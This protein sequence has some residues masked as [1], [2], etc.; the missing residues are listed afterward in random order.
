MIG[1]TLNLVFEDFR[2]QT[3]NEGDNLYVFHEVIDKIKKIF[4]HFHLS[5]SA[6]AALEQELQKSNQRGVKL[7]QHVPTQWIL[8]YQ[9]LDRFLQIADTVMFV[10]I[11]MNI[12]LPF[13]TAQYILFVQDLINCLN[14]CN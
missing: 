13:V 5:I 12:Y 14:D 9:M 7:I 11:K 10:I 4:T 6:T 8:T 2:K 3:T 1:H